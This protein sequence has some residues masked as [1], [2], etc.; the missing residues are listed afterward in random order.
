M[1]IKFFWFKD[2]LD[3]LLFSLNIENLNKKTNF[4]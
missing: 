2:E 3:D 1:N 4:N